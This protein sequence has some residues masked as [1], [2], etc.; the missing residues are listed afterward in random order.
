VAL[1]KHGKQ[2]PDPW[3]R[4]PDDAPIPGEGP[5]LVD[6]PRWKAER[7]ALLARGAPVGVCLR[8]GEEP[9]EIADDLGRLALVALDFPA[10][11]DGRA[12]SSARVLREQ[13]G[14]SGELR[15]VGDVLLEQLHFMDRVGFDAFEIDSDDPERDWRIAAN[16]MT[17]WYQPTGD[18]RRTVLQLRHD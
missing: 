13:L 10:F 18:G 2:V 9:A 15:A 6:L 1:L 7:D 3:Q 8:P 12:Y 5:V 17:L 14:Y 4:V 16:D 11:K